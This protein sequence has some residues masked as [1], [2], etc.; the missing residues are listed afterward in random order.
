[1]LEICWQESG[2]TS[3]RRSVH[4]TPASSPLFNECCCCCFSCRSCPTLLTPWTVALQAP[5]PWAFPGNNTG[6]GC[7]FLLQGIFPNQGSNP[8]PVLT[9][10]F[11]TTEPPGK[12]CLM[13]S[14]SQFEV[15][16][17][18]SQCSRNVYQFINFGHMSV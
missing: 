11:F 16:F 18:D 7:H 9:G 12:P 2:G 10:R 4:Q 15:G 17:A 3:L 6:L 1:M 14:K 5:C 8:S 13:N